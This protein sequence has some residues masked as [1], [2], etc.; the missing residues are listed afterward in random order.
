LFGDTKITNFDPPGLVEENIVQLDISVDHKLFGVDVVEAF[1]ELFEKIL[2]VFLL[3]LSPLSYVAEQVTALAKLH[4]EAHVSIG[5]KAIVEPHD[6][7]VVALLKY[8][9]FLHHSLFLFLFIP[10]NFLFDGFYGDKML[11]DFVAGQVDLA[12]G[13][14]S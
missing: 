6:V 2:S 4:N 5:F 3:E 1:D 12:K 13:T 9:H 10:E 8:G 7:G 11:A 14:P